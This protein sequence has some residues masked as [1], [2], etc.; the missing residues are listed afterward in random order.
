MEKVVWTKPS[1][2]IYSLVGKQ[3]QKKKYKG[4]LAVTIK[5]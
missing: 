1:K 4:F 5:T 2:N 3:K